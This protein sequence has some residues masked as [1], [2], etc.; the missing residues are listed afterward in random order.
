MAC[1]LALSWADVFDTQGHIL[2]SSSNLESRQLPL[3]AP[4]STLYEASRIRRM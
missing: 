2:A 1:R 4:A 3:P